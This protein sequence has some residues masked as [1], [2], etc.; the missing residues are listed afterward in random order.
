MRAFK[1]A[2]SLVLKPCFASGSTVTSAL[3][4]IVDQLSRAYETQVV[5]AKLNELEARLDQGRK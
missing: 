1:T 2:S 5:E 3:A 4:S